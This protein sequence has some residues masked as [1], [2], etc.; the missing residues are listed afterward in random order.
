MTTAVKSKLQLPFFKLVWLSL[1]LLPFQSITY[2]GKGF[3]SY[4]IELILM[5]TLNNSVY[6]LKDFYFKIGKGNVERHT[7]FLK[8][9]VYI[10][11]LGQF[12]GHI[13]KFSI[14]F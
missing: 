10:Y 6:M 5:S 7:C 4:M 8:F 1:Y 3:D 13:S 14:K 12:S 2:N 11:S 9:I